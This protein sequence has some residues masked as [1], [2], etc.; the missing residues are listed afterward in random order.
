M[1][2]AGHA[3]SLTPGIRLAG[4]RFSS[5]FDLWRR[6]CRGAGVL[7]LSYEARYAARPIPAHPGDRTVTLMSNAVE[8]VRGYVDHDTDAVQAALAGL[9]ADS[10]VEVYALLNGLLHSTIS[11]ME[12]TG[13]RWRLDE[14]VRHADEVATAAPPHYEFA[15]TEATRAWAR[16]DGS[17]MR[18][19]SGRDVLGAVHMTAVG[20]TALGLALWGRAGLLDVLEEF[21][22]IAGGLVDGA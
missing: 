2:A 6:V 14:L 5:P 18:A 15:I 8:V 7:L 16:G 19:L 10:R 21:D 12:L 17:A 13:R 9:D 4:G 3:G 1:R 22:R 20:V 11:I